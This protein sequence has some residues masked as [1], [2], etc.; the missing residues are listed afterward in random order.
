MPLPDAPGNV[1][2]GGMSEYRARD[3]G[4]EGGRAA[5]GAPPECNGSS[6]S[7]RS[8]QG[9]R[10]TAGGSPSVLES[11]PHRFIKYAVYRR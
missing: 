3:A 1:P 7:A 11:N 2:T 10:K 5:P 9:G 4:T 8:D 6:A